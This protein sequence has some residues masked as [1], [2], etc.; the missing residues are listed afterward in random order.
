ML[1]SKPGILLFDRFKPTSAFTAKINVINKGSIYFL[2]QT[3]QVTQ[4]QITNLGK[5]V[6]TAEKT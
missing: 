4:E 1:K 2:M 3:F 5:E 6:S